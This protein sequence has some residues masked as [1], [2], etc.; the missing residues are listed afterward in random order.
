M[1]VFN[2]ITPHFKGFT[3][4]YCQNMGIAHQNFPLAY[5]SPK[6]L[7][8]C[9]WNHF[10]QQI[11]VILPRNKSQVHKTR[12]LRQKSW[13]EGP[14]LPAKRIRHFCFLGHQF[15]SSSADHPD[16]PSDTPGAS[17]QVVFWHPGRHPLRILRVC[18]LHPQ[19]SNIDTKN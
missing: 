7:G 3:Q 15:P 19:K 17:K 2:C 16:P 12:P 13:L 1:L 4:Q 14:P 5:N 8:L 11:R 9:C 10:D 18:N 6:L